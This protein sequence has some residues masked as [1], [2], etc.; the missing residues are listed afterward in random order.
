M[1]PLTILI[2][3][4]QIIINSNFVESVD[5]IPC[6]E[7]VNAAGMALAGRILDDSTPPGYRLQDYY[8]VSIPTSRQRIFSK[9]RL[10]DRSA[11]RIST[12]VSTRM[13]NFPNSCITKP[14]SRIYTG[15]AF[16]KL[17]VSKNTQTK[18][19]NYYSQLQL[20]ARTGNLLLATTY[21]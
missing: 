19:A 17:F 15:A 14:K 6:T 8:P 20:S 16:S 3:F 12:R 10:F 13:R 4:L 21:N 9:L 2:V 1:L 7:N 5:H 11:R 18:K